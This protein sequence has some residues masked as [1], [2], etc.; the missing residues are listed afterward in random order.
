M[1]RQHLECNKTAQEQFA[2]ESDHQYHPTRSLYDDHTPNPYEQEEYQ[3]SV[4]CHR[5]TPV[6]RGTIAPHQILRNPYSTTIHTSPS[7]RR[8]AQGD[9]G[10]VK[11]P[12]RRAEEVERFYACNWEGCDKAYGAL[13]HLN[14][15]VRNAGHGPKREPRG[16]Y[17][18]PDH[19]D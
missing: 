18:N 1:S 2:D 13:N 4:S 6:V 15:H 9:C 3:W 10:Y 16:T 12:R 17:Y 11:R 19:S 8:T 5:A 14:T 7:G